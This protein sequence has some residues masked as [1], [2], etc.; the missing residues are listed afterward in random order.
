[1]SS[2]EIQKLEF[3]SNILSEDDKKNL[4][5]KEFVSSFFQHVSFG[6]LEN[7]CEQASQ[8]I[9]ADIAKKAFDILRKSPPKNEF[10]IKHILL[11]KHKLQVLFLHSFDKSFVVRSTKV[12]LATNKLVVDELV[13]PIFSPQRSDSGLTCCH[14]GSTAES[15]IAV[16]L[17]IDIEIPANYRESLRELYSKLTLVVDDFSVMQKWTQNILCD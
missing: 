11:E 4:V 8:N 15:L 1:M 12:W 7:L 6:Y 10:H 13:H 2:K 17:P 9:L 16:I 3:I 5:L 14:E